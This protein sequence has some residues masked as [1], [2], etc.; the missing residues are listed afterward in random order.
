MEIN[1]T[2]RSTNDYVYF[3][4]KTP[5]SN[6]WKSPDIPYDNHTFKSS[7][8]LFMYIKAKTFG[9]IEIANQLPGATHAEAKKLGRKVRGF[10]HRIWEKERE[11]A[12][13]VALK[14]KFSVDKDFRDTLMAEEYRNK[15][16]V[17]ASP[18]DNIW[19]IKISITQAY[20]GEKWNGIN[21]LGKLLT[22]LRDEELKK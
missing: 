1:K 5:L 11:N 18:Y 12:M 15:T 20:E 13:Y 10:D 19:G 14:A 6:W 21:L 9:D 16:F 22:Q 7:E 2:I 3:Y 4:Q 17:E 8:S